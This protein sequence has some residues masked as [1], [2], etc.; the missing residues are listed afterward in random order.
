LQQCKCATQNPRR[1]GLFGPF[2][3]WGLDNEGSFATPNRSSGVV[4][5]HWKPIYSSQA[6]EGWGVGWQHHIGTGISFSF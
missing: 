6:G 1:D 3:Q 5:A 2:S 4:F